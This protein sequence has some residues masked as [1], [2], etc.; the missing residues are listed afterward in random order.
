MRLLPASA[1][2]A[3]TALAAAAAAGAAEPAP[4]L[5]PVRS[6]TFPDRAYVLTLPSPAAVTAGR[7]T[8]RENGRPV[9]GVS[10]IP[11]AGQRTRTFATVLALDASNSMRG[12]AI[13]GAL[14]AARLFVARRPAGQPLGLLVFNDRVREVLPPTAAG[15]PIR[16]ALRRAPALRE[17]TRLYDAAVKAIETLRAAKITAGS[18]VLLTD[19]RDIG[20]RASAGQVASAARK[21]GVRLFAVG[22]RSRQFSPR[23]LAALARA[24]GGSYSE[25]ASAAALTAIYGTLS[26]RLAREYLIRYRSPAGPD[27]AV[28]V[29][30]EVPGTT[31]H[32]FARYRTPALPAGS[33]GPY[34]RSLVDRFLLS[35]LS[36]VLMSLVAAGAAGVVISLLL[37]RRQSPVRRRIAEFLSASTPAPAQ[38]PGR[39]QGRR[40]RLARRWQTRLERALERVPWW[41]RLKEEIEI[42]EFPIPA[43]PLVVGT[44]ALTLFFALLFALTLP[45]VFVPFSLGV[46]FIA[47]GS[48]RRKLS[49]KRERFAEQLP[50]NLTVLAASLRAGH[51]FVGALSAV[52]EEAEEPA[53]SELRRA[54][55]DEQ[56]G[57][58]IEEALVKVAQRMA[59]G[60]LEQVALVA[61]LQR[62]TG[63]NTAEVLD[64][65]VETVRQRF[66]LRRLVQALTAQG[67]IARWILTALPVAVTLIVLVLNPS[68]L[69]PL[70]HTG[71]GQVLLALSIALVIAGSIAIKRIVDIDL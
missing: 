2:T 48:V 42:A 4:V 16:F 8:V 36:A 71:S 34:H 33:P 31:R 17:G 27:L 40:R 21:A 52:V 23:P 56:L 43:L 37:Q 57:M 15:G 1:L 39:G 69:S 68:Y 13:E 38:A 60:D 46:P 70:F 45:P 10:V 11:A 32:A 49:R 7:V 51:S 50:D 22:L 64:T 47:L 44:A 59:N 25:A 55:A 20:S 26:E 63:G 30:V 12:E 9:G 29:E 35:P 66:E 62:D 41:D 14:A 19:G 58:P 67:R 18:V 6:I 53:R 61:A 24:T 65:V 54:L 5:T 3:A 28:R